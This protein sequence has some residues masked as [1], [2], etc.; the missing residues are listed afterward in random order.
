MKKRWLYVL[1]ISVILFGL[2]ACG[3][4]SVTGITG[5]VSDGESPISDADV[6]LY[7]YNADTKA[8]ETKIAE[9]KTDSKGQYTLRDFEPGMYAFQVNVSAQSV[10]D[11]PCTAS[12]AFLVDENT[13]AQIVAFKLDAGGYL[14][15]FSIDDV[16][17]VE[18]KMITRDLNTKYCQ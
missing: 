1:V 14:A 11:L 2:S 5:K 9:G 15:V 6:M 18:G 7:T 3:S 12:G 17:V 16:E 13:W 8:L 4:T 10:S